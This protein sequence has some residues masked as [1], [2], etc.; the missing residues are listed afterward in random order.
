MTEIV[1]LKY[2]YHNQYLKYQKKW[3]IG[4]ELFG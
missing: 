1:I 2:Q 3:R 4:I